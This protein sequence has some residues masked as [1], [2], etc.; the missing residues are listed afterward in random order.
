MPLFCL[1]HEEPLLLVTVV[2]WLARSVKEAPM[3]NISFNFWWQIYS[4]NQDLLYIKERVSVETVARHG[5]SPFWKVC[6]FAVSEISE[7][8]AGFSIN[9][10]EYWK[11]YMGRK[12]S[13]WW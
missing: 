11:M 9:T 6:P 13:G 4:G 3:L 2:E 7:N 10:T 8:N 5:N 1:Q 12:W